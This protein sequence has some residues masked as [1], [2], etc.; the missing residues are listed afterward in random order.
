[1]TTTL[2]LATV[3]YSSRRALPRLAASERSEA[4]HIV[5]GYDYLPTPTLPVVRLEVD[6]WAPT[7]TSPERRPVMH[8]LATSAILA[9][10]V[11][12]SLCW[13]VVWS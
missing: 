2:H 3:K 9:V 12:L 7:E 1:M 4:W 11:V 13:A 10:I 6:H 5:N 8:V